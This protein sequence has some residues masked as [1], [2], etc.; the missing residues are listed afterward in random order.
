MGS[1]LNKR[2]RK[3]CDPDIPSQLS[4]KIGRLASVNSCPKAESRRRVESPSTYHSTPADHGGT[5][6]R[7]ACGLRIRDTLESCGV[8]SR[9]ADRV[10]H[11]LDTRRSRAELQPLESSRARRSCRCRNPWWKSGSASGD[12]GFEERRTRT[13]RP[14]SRNGRTIENRIDRFIRA[15]HWDCL[16]RNKSSG[17]WLALVAIQRACRTRYAG[18]VTNRTDRCQ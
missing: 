17:P 15:C 18:W 2:I 5:R 3:L 8:V 1:I 13:H 14:S 12:L 4:R 10:L 6:D 11:S 16:L 9:L 7:G